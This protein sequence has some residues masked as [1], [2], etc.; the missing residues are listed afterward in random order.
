MSLYTHP[1]RPSARGPGGRLPGSIR[2]D[3]L[4][5]EGRAAVAE[6][7]HGVGVLCKDTHRDGGDR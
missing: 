3:A 6:A 1:L 4:A 2:T 5:D 7:G